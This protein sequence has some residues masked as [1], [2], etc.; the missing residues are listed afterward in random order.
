MTAAEHAQ[1]ELALIDAVGR[2]VRTKSGVE[3]APT[4]PVARV[5]VDSPLPHL[6]RPFDYLVTEAQHDQVSAGVRVR[7]RFAGKDVGGLVLERVAA[8]EHAGR[9]TPLS[10]VVSDLPVLTDHTE[11][12]VRAVAD[13]YAGTFMDVARAAVPPRHARVE[14]EFVGRFV[15]RVVSEEE[16]SPLGPVVAVA[17]WAR[18]TGGEALLARLSVPGV[19]SPRPRAVW[20]ALPS[21][22]VPVRVAELVVATCAAGLGSVV[23]VPD[24]RDVE[25]FSKALVEVLGDVRVVRLTADLGPAARYRAFMRVLV[26]GALV[27]VGTRAAAFAPVRDLGLA[28]IW[29]D[30]DDLHSD[31]HAPYWHAREVLALRASESGAALVLG[32][33]S[34][35]VEAA[36]ALQ[37]GWAREVAAPRAMVRLAAPRVTGT[38]ESDLARDPAA[39]SARL[40]HRAFTTARKALESGPVLVQV[41]RRGYVPA[42]ACQRCRALARCAEC[43]GP[44]QATSGHAVPSC[45]WCGRLGADHACAECGGRTLRAVTVGAGRTAEELGRAFPLVPVITSGRDG[46]V[47]VVSERPALVVCT[48]GAEPVALGGYAAA[49]LLDARALLDRVDLRSDEE[50][51]RRWVNAASLVR[52]S[53]EGGRVVILADAA[54]PAV[55][56]LV[57]WDPAGFA[58]REWQERV[59]LRLP[60]PWRVVEVSGAPHDVQSFLD[61]LELPPSGKVLGPVPIDIRGEVRS[62]ALISATHDEGAVLAAA[63]KVTSSVRSASKTGGPVTVRFDPVAIG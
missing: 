42:L 19:E 60:P 10:R 28:V 29:D 63:C 32:A 61:N 57:R 43:T 48:P 46:V 49:L 8:S 39:Q 2:T 40:P 18:Y 44:L 22:D 59:T 16:R 23:V 21:D 26:G 7:V 34:R 50:A 20:T 14:A 3:A 30:G 55:Q 58:E 47:E 6:D 35:S 15:G 33:H 52:P 56:A 11:W 4:S 53:A 12:L 38:D 27:V 37:A 24:A 45:R 54:I 31:L 25:R 41:P 13:R 36:Q 62:R 51:L 5:M 9:L 1:A 17:G